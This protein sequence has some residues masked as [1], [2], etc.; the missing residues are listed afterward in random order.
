MGT[1]LSSESFVNE[2]RLIVGSDGQIGSSLCKHFQASGLP[3]VR[4]TRRETAA[5]SSTIRLDLAAPAT[6]WPGF[7]EVRS[8]VLCGAVTNGEQCRLNPSATRHVNVYQTVRLAERLVE[9]GAFVVFLSSNAVFDGSKPLRSPNEPVCPMTEYGRQKADAEVE[10]RSLRDRCAIVRL[11]KVFHG[12]LAL[13]QG[14]LG[15]LR[16]QKAIS[17]YSDYVCAPISL[18]A[19][20]RAI[21]MVVENELAGVWQLSARTDVAYDGIARTLARLN[22]LD[23]SLIRPI[24]ARQTANLE[25]VPQY[26]TMDASQSE[27]SLGFRIPDP[28]EVINTLNII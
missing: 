23:E 14:W 4:T 17:P 11:T 27:A 21:G 3:T 13:L 10:L 25:H 20:V 24:A 22:K 12:G 16:N 1:V 26:S 5:D 18:E 15:D 8:A 9:Q 2:L 28:L 6:S 7:R 19:V